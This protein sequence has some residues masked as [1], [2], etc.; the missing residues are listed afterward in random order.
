MPS[1]FMGHLAWS[2]VPADEKV[3]RNTATPVD[4]LKPAAVMDDMPEQQEIET[5]SDPN[6]G[7]VNRTLASHWVQGTKTSPEWIPRVSAVTDS[8]RIINE[9]VSSS[10]TAAS[11]EQAGNVNPNLSYAVGIEPVQDLG[12][13]GGF[14][15]T[16]FKTHERDIQATMGDE[17][18]VAP[19]YNQR[20]TQDVSESGKKN[21]RRSAQGSLYDSFW[22][23][24]AA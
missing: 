24:G 2:G 23:G 4:D 12:Q 13:A 3:V 11:R 6:L 1:L 7:M 5:D 10:G 18:T 16:Y 17:M 14:G 22:A 8:T 19:G 15:E 20:K 9:Q 21:A